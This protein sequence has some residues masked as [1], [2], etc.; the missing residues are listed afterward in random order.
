M[1]LASMALALLCPLYAAAQ[2]IL[3]ISVPFVTT[4]VGSIVTIPVSVAGAS[5]LGFFQFDLGYAPQVVAADPNGVTAGTMLSD[6][7][8]F[9]SPGTVDAV[10][11]RIIGV[12]SFGTAVEG[13]GTIAFVRF[14]ALA[15]G[16]SP[17]TL[18]HAF[19]NLEDQGVQITN[20]QIM[21]VVLPPIPLSPALPLLITAL[22]AA[23]AWLFWRRRRLA[24]RDRPGPGPRRAGSIE[25]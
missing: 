9:S 8:F 18:S 19:L 12:S 20:G 2:G 1:R 23:S 17:L 10:G 13:S 25:G 16:V 7:W 15:V 22:L 11:G 5:G 4:T 14:R 21:V 6:D 24:S 3:G